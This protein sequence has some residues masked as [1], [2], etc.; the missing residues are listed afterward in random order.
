[1]PTTTDA[2]PPTPIHTDES[3]APTDAL[4]ATLRLSRAETAAAGAPTAPLDRLLLS[5]QDMRRLGLRAG[6]WV[7]ITTAESASAAVADAASDGDE[8]P[9][10]G[11]VADS[12]SEGGGAGGMAVMRAWPAV[13]VALPAGTVGFLI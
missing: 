2:Y 11:S 13:G 3:L 9:Q 6:H 4:D 10:E 8:A 12:S 1:M 5:P 7:G